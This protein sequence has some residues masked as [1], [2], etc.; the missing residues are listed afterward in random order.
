MSGNFCEEKTRRKR[1]TWHHHQVHQARSRFNR[2]CHP[3]ERNPSLGV[4]VLEWYHPTVMSLQG[5]KPGKGAPPALP[6]A[7]LILCLATFSSASPQQPRSNLFDLLNRAASADLHTREM[8]FNDLMAY[9][10]S[11]ARERVTVSDKAEILNQFFSRHPDQA[12]AVKSGLIQLLDK[13][14]ETFLGKSVQ[15][16]TYGEQDM[17]HYADVIDVVSSLDDERAIPPLAGAITTGGMATRGLV[18]Y[19]KKSLGPVMEQFKNGSPRTRSAALGAAVTI[20][21]A[22]HDAAS[23]AQSVELLRSSLTD[24][25]FVVREEAV[26]LLDCS[27]DRLDFVPML[28]Q[29]AKT[30]PSR[31]P[32]R[33]DD[34]VDGNW[35]YP[36]RVQARRVLR[37]IQNKKTCKP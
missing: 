1:S 23:G 22:S 17:E 28:E 20:L 33:T 29:L 16:G 2:V 31:Y 4:D 15:A 6:L 12:E 24:P 8:A 26:M 34:G 30:D 35:H 10:A 9:L 36:V 11:D 3:K 21:R 7:V 5:E 27:E 13:E 37:D 32:G 18:Q 19:G 25:E 14:N